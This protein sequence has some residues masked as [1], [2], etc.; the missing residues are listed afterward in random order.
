MVTIGIWCI[1]HPVLAE[2]EG[3]QTDADGIR[4]GMGGSLVVTS[5]TGR[6][7]M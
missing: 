5:G 1:T 4:G 7:A 2:M 6:I 3:E